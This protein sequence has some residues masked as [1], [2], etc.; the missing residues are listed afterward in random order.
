MDTRI[1]SAQFDNSS[2]G[3]KYSDLYFGKSSKTIGQ[4]YSVI[5]ESRAFETLRKSTKVL[6]QIHLKY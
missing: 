3:E 1:N 5:R 2:L 4:K 6:G